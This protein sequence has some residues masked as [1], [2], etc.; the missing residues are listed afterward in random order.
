MD[1]N[2]A[3]ISAIRCEIAAAGGRIPFARFME[4]ALYHPQQGYYRTGPA[5]IGRQGDYFTSVSVGPLLG[6]IL[7]RQFQQWGVT[8]VLE[9]GGQRGQLRADVLATAPGLQ[10][11]VIEAGDSLPEQITGCVF[12]NEFLDA[13]PV[14]R[15]HGDQEVYVTQDFCEVLGPLSDPRLPRLPAGYRSEV[16]LRALDW[17][18]TIA[19]RL[20]SGFVLTIDYGFERAEYFAPH[21]AA[22]HLQCYYRHTKSGNPYDH[23]GEQDLT[24]HVDFTSLIEHGQSLGLEPVLFTDQAHYLLQVG[25]AEIAAI[26]ARTAG[27]LSAERNAIHQ[28]LHST[29]GRAFKVLIQRKHSTV[30]F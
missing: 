27:Q 24:A 10:Y 18:S 21:H 28:L 4:L 20:T 23:I 15:I 3:L 14:H 29:M 11:R 26:V 2:P 9:F 13:L 8:E 7:A 17:L 16:N 22:G 1:G 12:S 25:E 30:A 6:R 5:R 19:R